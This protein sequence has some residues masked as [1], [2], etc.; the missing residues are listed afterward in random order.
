MVVIFLGMLK[1][2]GEQI[3]EDIV[4]LSRKTRKMVCVVW[5]DPPNGAIRILQENSIPT[6]EDPIR[7]IKA[8]SVVVRY[9]DYLRKSELSELT[10]VD[11]QGHK[12]GSITQRRF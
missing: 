9:A 1:N 5:M 12:R 4:E 8:I 11:L 2:F 6:F 10:A 3:I 7:C